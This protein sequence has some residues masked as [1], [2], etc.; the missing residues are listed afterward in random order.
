MIVIGQKRAMSGS[1][2]DK[3]VLAIFFHRDF[4]C[5]PSITG[6][7][8]TTQN[9]S[10]NLI[11]SS[12]AFRTHLLGLHYGFSHTMAAPRIANR[13][14]LSRL[15]GPRL[16]STTIFATTRG[17]LSQR[18]FAS[19]TKLWQDIQTPSDGSHTRSVALLMLP[20]RATKSEIESL[21]KSKGCDMY[22]FHHFKSI[23]YTW[24]MIYKHVARECR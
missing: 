7:T 16:S 23:Y 11:K 22:V 1:L 15:A 14:L 13:H 5:R 20:R 4:S 2:I 21:L 9:T 3:M 17:F 10:P 6:V 12:T 8:T 24:L 19:S 18:S